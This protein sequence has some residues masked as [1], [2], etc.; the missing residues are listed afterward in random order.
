MMCG[1]EELYTSLDRFGLDVDKL[2]MRNSE[3]GY[4]GA[5]ITSWQSL[6]RS[7]LGAVAQVGGFGQHGVSAEASLGRGTGGGVSGGAGKLPRCGQAGENGSRDLHKT[8]SRHSRSGTSVEAGGTGAAGKVI[9]KLTRRAKVQHFFLLILLTE[10]A[11]LERDKSSL[12][13]FK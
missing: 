6:M 8:I 7:G 12:F 5:Q 13:S 3:L 2:P 1:T 11:A 9:A 10:Y 4:S